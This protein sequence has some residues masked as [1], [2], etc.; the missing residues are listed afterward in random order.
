M[1][2]YPCLHLDLK[3]ILDDR[4]RRGKLRHIAVYIPGSVLWLQGVQ[5]TTCATYLLPYA[6]ISPHQLYKPDKH[7]ICLA[8]KKKSYVACT[9]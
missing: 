1:I 4:V 2:L 5:L 3:C 6:S 9:G 8:K 7:H